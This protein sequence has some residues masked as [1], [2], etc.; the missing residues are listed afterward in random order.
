MARVVLTRRAETDLDDIWL[1]IALENPIAADG[2]ID[3]I[4]DHAKTISE[5][6]Q[7]GRARPELAAELRSFPEGSYIV[8]YEP[9]ADGVRIIRVLH[10]ARDV[11][12]IFAEDNDLD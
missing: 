7:A 12:A 2:V 1:H 5:Q 3:A 4:V 6:P 10:G 8:F 11:D 9:M